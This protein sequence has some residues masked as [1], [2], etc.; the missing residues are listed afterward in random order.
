MKIQ[1][2]YASKD[3]IK[4]VK[5]QHI[6][7]EKTYVRHICDKGLVSRIYKELLQFNNYKMSQ[8]LKDLNKAK[9]LNKHFSK[10]DTQMANKHVKKC[11]MS[12]VIRANHSGKQFGN[13]LKS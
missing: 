12:F 13:P 4:K 1:N 7:W 9:D 6:K 3:T 5:R 11:S 10:G 8:F 2:L